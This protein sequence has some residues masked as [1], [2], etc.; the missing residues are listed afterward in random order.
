[1]LSFQPGDVTDAGD[2]RRMIGEHRPDTLVYLAVPPVL[3]ESVLAA[4]AEAKL[5][6]TDAVAIEKPFGTDPTSARHL[7]EILRL[8]LPHPTIFRID[9]FRSDEAGR[10][11]ATQPATHPGWIPNPSQVFATP[12]RAQRP[13]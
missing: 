4:L 11:A 9:H 12:I 2:L 3:L 13:P 7:N 10:D 6:T 1:M 8:Q 5:R